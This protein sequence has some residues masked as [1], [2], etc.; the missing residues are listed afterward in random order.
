M[1]T[2]GD[3]R[4]W[5]GPG[6]GPHTVCQP[7]RD[8]NETLTLRRPSGVSHTEDDMIATTKRTSSRAGQGRTSHATGSSCNPSLTSTSRWLLVVVLLVSSLSLPADAACSG[9]SCPTGCACSDVGSSGSCRVDCSSVT[10]INLAS[11][12]SSV[13]PAN[14]VTQL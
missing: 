9:L 14:K 13:T 8:S 4:S 10:S 11:L 7:R 5:H 2:S 6:P 3:I 12:S 1:G